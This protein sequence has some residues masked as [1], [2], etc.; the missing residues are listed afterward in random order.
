MFS[1]IVILLIP[2]IIMGIFVYGNFTNIL[3]EEVLINNLNR[4]NNISKQIDTELFQLKQIQSQIYLNKNLRPFYFQN[5][6][7]KGKIARDELRNYTTTNSLLDDIIL[8]YQGDNFLY[9]STSSYTID[10]FINHIYQY[11]NWTEDEFKKTLL[12]IKAPILRLGEVVT[13]FP[14]EKE[15]MLTFL[16][17]L[18]N[19]NI[20]TYGAV[21]FLV[22]EQAFQELLKQEVKEYDEN[23]I[24]LDENNNIITALRHEEYFYSQ[25]F[26]DFLS[27]PNKA[28]QEVLTLHDINYFVSY[29]ASPQTKWSYLTLTP[30]E[31]VMAK[32][33]MAHK[34]F[35]Y[36]LIL[37][38]LIG[39]IATYGMITLNYNPIHQLKL[40]TEKLWN[41]AT[42]NNEI[43]AIKN[44]LEHLSNE[45]LQLQGKVKA[46]QTTAKPYFLFQIL[47]GH[48][49]NINE[50]NK[51]GKELGIHFTRNSFFVAV[52]QIHCSQA[53]MKE[54]KSQPIIQII[55]KQLPDFIDGYG[56]EHFQNHTFIF[57]FNIDA[58]FTSEAKHFLTEL[59]QNIL[60][61]QIPY[62]ITIGVG[63]IYSSI[64]SIP[65]SYLEAMTALDYR[66]IQG[67]GKLI[68]FEQ[69]MDQRTDL[70]IYPSKQIT[71]LQ[72]CMKQGQIEQVERILEEILNFIQ[73][74]PMPLFMARG[75]CF[76]L[77]NSIVHTM[78]ELHQRFVFDTKYPDIMAL[79][80]IETVEELTDIIKQLCFEMHHYLEQH[81]EQQEQTLIQ[82][83]I[84]YLEKNFTS[85]QFSIQNTADEFQMSLPA[86]SQYFKDKT[87]QT[88]SDY[89]TYL[90]M[91]T[92]KKLL[93][94]EEMTL[95]DIAAHVGY[96]NVSS[97]IRRFKQLTGT[98][99]GEYRKQHSA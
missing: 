74:T 71:L 32:V 80:Q 8:Y 96:Y 69:V 41:S 64:S 62:P 89:V 91:E 75:L 92:A 33:K 94:T 30:V 58:S 90:R 42:C 20:S 22:H 88:L 47:N 51:K 84:T 14:N 66:F 45:N 85:H 73:N 29:V 31:Q 18:S 97:F 68:Y 4:L 99:P 61:K 15:K 49:K 23:S 11:D 63:T 48:I 5:S 95:K 54:L 36:V 86:F 3:K 38:L 83:I 27:L 60:K 79:S 81:K 67:N 53:F 98:T 77:I 39:S 43:D 37:I 24:I 19:E 28:N 70:D 7:L 46:H 35:M 93:V 34:K 6:P 78:H 16:Y 13:I 17:P 12:S 50:I 1:Y 52:F 26:Q 57:I 21:L 56:R 2:I 82:D 9:S 72:H 10:R 40:Y 59:Q 76:N 65:D 87:G 55:E 44:T 25:D